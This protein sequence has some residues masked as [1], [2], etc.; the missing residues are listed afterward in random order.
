MTDISKYEVRE[1]EV[2]RK[3]VLENKMPV[4]NISKYEAVPEMPTVCPNENLLKTVRT[5]RSLPAKVLYDFNPL[6]DDD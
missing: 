4:A 1:G 3:P 6:D 5:L 2:W